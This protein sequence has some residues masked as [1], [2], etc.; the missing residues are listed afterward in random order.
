MKNIEF[1]KIKQEINSDSP[2]EEFR[3]WLNHDSKNREMVQRVK[4]YYDGELDD[5]IKEAEVDACWKEFERREFK[6][7]RLVINIAASIAAAVAILFISINLF[8]KETMIEPQN[9]KANVEIKKSNQ[10]DEI[11]LS[12]KKGE[13]HI[14]AQTDKIDLTIDTTVMIDEMH[15]IS[16]PRGKSLTVKLSD[17]TVVYLN[18]LTEFTYPTSFSS[19]ETRNVTLK[20]EAYFEVAHDEKKQFIVE[21]QGVNVK[22][23]GTKFNVNSNKVGL[24]E[25]VLV[26]GSVAVNETMLR[27]NF[28]LTYTT[29]TSGVTIEKVDVTNYISWIDDIYHFNRWP[30]VEIMNSLATWYDIEVIYEDSDVKQLEFICNIPR[31]HTINEVLNILKTCGKINYRISGNKIYIGSIK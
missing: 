28:K 15:T 4:K 2:S 11:V 19:S 21:V 3:Q 29:A 12:T 22:V 8:D 10:I 27:P 23:Y 20:G 24:I 1:D 14:I 18:S 16:I 9:K 5:N 25:T 17:G 6:K 30:L 26:E 31:H 13:K 7:H